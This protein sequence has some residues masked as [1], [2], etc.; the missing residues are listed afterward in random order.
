M[1]WSGNC[2]RVSAC[3]DI[4]EWRR[5]R[6]TEEWAP[7]QGVRL[8]LFQPFLPCGNAGLNLLVLMYF[9]LRETWSLDF[10]LKTPKFQMLAQNLKTDCIY[11]FCIRIWSEG[12]QFETSDFELC[13]KIFNLRTCLCVFVC[14]CMCLCCCCNKYLVE[15]EK[16]KE[17]SHTVRRVL[18]H[19]GELDT[20]YKK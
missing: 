17:L 13:L 5:G 10:Y 8:T 19:W 16:K 2:P 18:K 20:L 9:F 11:M 7:F 6:Y 4:T 12:H 14:L 15:T 1:Q 3:L